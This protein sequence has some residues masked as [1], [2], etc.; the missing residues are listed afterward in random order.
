[1]E[2]VLIRVTCPDPDCRAGWYLR[3]LQLKI[4]P[5]EL[6]VTAQGVTQKLLLEIQTERQGPVECI[7]CGSSA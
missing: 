4:T 3:G 5:L 7:A 2:S 1:M 6:E